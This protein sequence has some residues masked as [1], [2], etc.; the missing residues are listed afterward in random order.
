[1]NKYYLADLIF[2]ANIQIT[3]L[4]KYQTIKW[5]AWIR[6]AC[7]VVDINCDDYIQSIISFRQSERPIYKGELI[8]VRLVLNDKNIQTLSKLV[9]GMYN[10]PITGE[11]NR[12]S[13]NF[14]ACM[15]AVTGTC[16][17]KDL[18]ELKYS[19]VQKEVDALIKRKSFHLEFYTP[20]RIT[21]PSGLKPHNSNEE[22]RFAHCDFFVSNKI[23]LSHLASKVNYDGLDSENSILSGTSN[24]I[25]SDLEWEDIIYNSKHPKSIGG[26]TGSIC[27][28]AV[29]DKKLAKR[30]VF[31]QYI[32][33]GKSTRL[34]FG[35]YKIPEI[36]SI[37][38]IALPYQN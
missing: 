35:F 7:H 20:T 21:L 30:L 32:G 19:Y 31:G 23:A 17:S 22:Q 38:N 1:M 15:D 4:P 34:G 37:R 3:N 29:C 13:F 36:D 14:V 24:V 28:D 33:C 10:S 11:Y 12:A 8:R 18:Q 6:Y 16:I 2:S 25:S 9:N 5:T 27:F 26:V